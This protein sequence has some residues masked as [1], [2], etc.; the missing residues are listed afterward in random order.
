[1]LGGQPLSEISWVRPK[2]L[3]V[4]WQPHSHTLAFVTHLTSKLNLNANLHSVVVTVQHGHD[5][6]VVDVDSLHISDVMK[7]S[8]NARHLHDG[9]TS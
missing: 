5:D 9:Q 3:S 6:L 8:G 4:F 7:W 2:R 1:M